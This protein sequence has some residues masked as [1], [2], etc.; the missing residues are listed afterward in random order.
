[1]H[2]FNVFNFAICDEVMGLT[3]D[4]KASLS[5][6]P[7]AQQ[8]ILEQLFSSHIELFKPEMECCNSYKASLKLK[9]GAILKFFKSRPIPFS[10]L[11]AV[12]MEVDHF[13][14]AGI[15]KPV[16]TSQWATPIVVVP[17]PDST[18]HL[19]G[20]F[21]VTVNPQLEVEQY[22]KVPCITRTRV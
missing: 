4:S 2:W 21:K 6:C 15:W 1:M 22:P 7:S 8:A 12:N 3:G 17:K 13:T 18:V 5:S 14:R 11:A 10:Q 19:C 16:K 20:D 9:P